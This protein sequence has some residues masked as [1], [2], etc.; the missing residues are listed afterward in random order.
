M[1]MLID[2][3]AQLFDW[4]KGV[5]KLSIVERGLSLILV[6][7]FLLTILGIVLNN[8]G[9][10]PAPLDRLVPLDYFE[11]IK[12]AFSLVL[13]VEVIELI[14][15]ISSSVSLAVGKQ[16]EIMG[17]LLLRET[18]TDIG[19]LRGIIDL[20]RDKED[21][22]Q[23]AVTALGGLS[24]FIMRGVFAR[25]RYVQENKDVKGYINAK[26]LI[27]LLLFTVFIG[28]GAYD[29]YGIFVMGNKPVFFKIFY[30]SLIFTDILLVLVGQYYMPCFHATFRSSGYAVGTLI[31]RLSFGAESHAVGAGLCVFAGLYIL[32]LTWAAS[33]FQP[34]EKK[35]LGSDAAVPE[36]PKEL[37]P[38]KAVE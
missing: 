30:S 18:F 6:F 8:M 27:A 25:W 4:L 36:I 31:M 24:L 11:A 28:A 3:S 10:L 2:K 34:A 21:L 20:A 9:V 15:A 32:G 35:V 38:Q 5:W 16:L 26:K 1:S 13:A 12:M 14:I 7:S 17:L 22:I 19:Q 23:I 37:K 33:Y 29:M